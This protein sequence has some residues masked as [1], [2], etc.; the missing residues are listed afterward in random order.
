LR[1]VSQPVLVGFFAI[2]GFKLNLKDLADM[3]FI[4]GA[5][6]VFRLLGKLLGAGL[7]VRWSRMNE[8]RENLGQ[9]MLAQATIAIG[10]ADFVAAH[11]KSDSADRF[12]MILLGS[13]V[14]FEVIGPLLTKRVAKHAGEV[15]ALTLLRR[16]AAVP[17]TTSTLATTWEALLRAVGI[18]SMPKRAGKGLLLVRHVMRANVKS[19]PADA[20]FTELLH[21]VEESRFNHFPVVDNDGNLVGVIHFADLRGLIYDPILSKLITAVDVADQASQAAAADLP[22]EEVLTLFQQGDFGSLPVI[23]SAQSRKV[24]GIVEQR[25]VLRAVHLT[26]SE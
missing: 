18:G 3:Q 23:E 10:L 16:H 12:G 6:V 26:R 17:G 21:H 7:G 2:A 11:W 25:D 1:V 15:K 5:Y 20:D 19:I 8:L 9:S 24:V 13:V 22:L 4:G 14:I